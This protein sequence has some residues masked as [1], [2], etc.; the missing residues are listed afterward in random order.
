M[1]DSCVVEGVVGQ[2]HIALFLIERHRVQL[3]IE[4]TA[5]GALCS[6]LSL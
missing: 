5:A 3:R 2:F 6:S 4:D 1:Q